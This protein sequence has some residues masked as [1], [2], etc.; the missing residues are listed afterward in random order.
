MMMIVNVVPMIMVMIIN[1]L[2]QFH[3]LV[4]SKL[5]SVPLKVLTVTV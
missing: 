5:S 3:I 4:S 2:V 1:G